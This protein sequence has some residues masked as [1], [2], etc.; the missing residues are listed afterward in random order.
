VKAAI[1]PGYRHSTT[2]ERVET[3]MIFCL[4]GFCVLSVVER[5][6]ML[7][8]HRYPKFCYRGG[9]KFRSSK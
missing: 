6:P 8:V 4:D 5:M 1:W 9:K 3:Y 2:S 7:L